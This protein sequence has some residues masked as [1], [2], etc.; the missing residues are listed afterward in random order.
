MTLGVC[1]L[2]L[3]VCGICWLGLDYLQVKTSANQIM[4]RRC[5]YKSRITAGRHVCGLPLAE[6]AIC[7][8]NMSDDEFN[9]CSGSTAIILKMDKVVDVMDV[10]DKQV[11]Q[12]VTPS[13]SGA[14]AGAALFGT[15]GAV[16]GGR[17]RTHTKEQNVH[18]IV[19]NYINQQDTMANICLELSDK[20]DIEESRIMSGIFHHDRPNQP[21][22][23]EL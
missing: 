10:T 23:V 9:F 11:L 14:V 17:A 3:V 5:G 7:S 1:L 18:Y 20:L 13:I 4:L 22:Q 19:F 6:N 21:T 2:L 15:L 16:I 12:S 8:V